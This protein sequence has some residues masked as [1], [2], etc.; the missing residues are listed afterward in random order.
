MSKRSFTAGGEH[1]QREDI[2][3]G[4]ISVTFHIKKLN[5]LVPVK[6]QRYDDELLAGTIR[7]PLHLL[8]CSFLHIPAVKGLI[9]LLMVFSSSLC[10]KHCLLNA[11]RIHFFLLQDAANARSSGDE[12]I[13]VAAETCLNTPKMLHFRINFILSGRHKSFARRCTM[14]NVDKTAHQY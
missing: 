4:N 12:L 9:W 1:L 5:T 3:L 13:L 10:W 8:V 11:A 2:F 6:W 14:D 7:D